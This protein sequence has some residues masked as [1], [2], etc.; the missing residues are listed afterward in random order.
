MPSIPGIDRSI[1]TTSGRSLSAATT[2]ARPSAAS[3]TTSTDVLLLEHRAQPLAHDLVVVD[4][5]H[6]YGR[7]H[8]PA[9]PG[10][11]TLTRVPS[12]RH[13]LDP[14]LAL[15]RA[16][17]LAHPHEAQPARGGRHRLGRELLE[18]ASV[19]GD[20]QVDAVAVLPQPDRDARSA[21]RASP[22]C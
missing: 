13:A 18:P 2:A 5:Q 12:S 4:D 9:S 20:R 19:V 8:A 14:Q 22:R 6:P 15:L 7:A 10:I 1:S 21:S 17:A 3:P 11:V 16:R